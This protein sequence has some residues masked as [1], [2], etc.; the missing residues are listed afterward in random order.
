MYDV[1]IHYFIHHN[2]DSPAH[3][4]DYKYFTERNQYFFRIVNI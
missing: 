4:T 3:W 1:L 2:T